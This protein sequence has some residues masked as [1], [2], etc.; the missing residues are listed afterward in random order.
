MIAADDYPICESRLKQGLVIRWII[1]LNWQANGVEHLV[2][3][4]LKQR[5]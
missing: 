2:T 5:S 1:H 3:K 4:A